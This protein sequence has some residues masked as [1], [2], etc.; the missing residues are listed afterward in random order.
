[1]TIVNAA[2]MVGMIL[3]EPSGENRIVI[4]AGALDELTPTHVTA[5]GPQLAY[6]DIAIVSLEIP[7]ETAC[8]ALRVARQAGTRTLLNPAP[9]HALPDEVWGDIDVITPNRTE[10]AILL[11]L[12]PDS[13]EPASALAAE[14]HARG[15]GTVVITLGADGALIHDSSGAR[16][17]PRL[18]WRPHGPSSY[19]PRHR[20]HDRSRRHLHRGPRRR[21]RRWSIS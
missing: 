11:G 9:A 19:P 20:R 2:T 5:F 8:A 6:A 1:M 13:A 15:A 14:L 3:V 10:A 16:T 18:L 17:V 7:V 12:G 4:A 21:A